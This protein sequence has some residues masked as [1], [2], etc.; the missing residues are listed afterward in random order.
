MNTYESILIC[1]TALFAIDVTG[2]MLFQGHLVKGTCNRFNKQFTAT[3]L[4][5]YIIQ[6]SHR[7][8]DNLI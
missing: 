2:T 1:I 6:L 3:F 8:E 4:I 7:C 5:A